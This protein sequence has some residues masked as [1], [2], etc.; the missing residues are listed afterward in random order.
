MKETWPQFGTKSLVNHS[1]LLFNPCYPCHPWFISR[2]F[3]HGLWRR[4]SCRRVLATFQSPVPSCGKAS[5][6]S[7]ATGTR[8]RDW[9]VPRTRRLES[10]RN[11]VWPPGVM[12][13]TF[14]PPS[15]ETNESRQ[16]QRYHLRPAA[17]PVVHP[18]ASYVHGMIQAE[19]PRVKWSGSNLGKEAKTHPEKLSLVACQRRETTPDGSRNRQSI[20]KGKLE[21]PKQPDLSGAPDERASRAAINPAK[22]EKLR[23]ELKS[24]HRPRLMQT[25]KPGRV[26]HGERIAEIIPCR[27]WRNGNSGPV[28][29]LQFGLLLQ[30]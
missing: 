7:D 11:G 29:A 1:T 8:T 10:L 28:G 24:F 21:V 19:L 6:K 17:A 4:H 18:P 14:S 22:S 12:E 26:G 13:W 5:G 27:P 23:L 16:I 25:E 30:H 9:K 2:Q 15:Q 20:P 3:N